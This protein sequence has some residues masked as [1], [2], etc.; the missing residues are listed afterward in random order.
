VDPA[1]AIDPADVLARQGVLDHLALERTG[2]RRGVRAGQAE[3]LDRCGHPERLVRP[4]R[5]VSGDVV[6]ERALNVGDGGEDPGREQLVA[7]GAVEPLD[8]AGGGRRA[9]R[10]EQVEDPVL[11]ADPVEQDLVSRSGGTPVEH[12]SVVREHRLGHP[13]GGERLREGLAER[14]CGGAGHRR[15]HDAEP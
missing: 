4:K 14:A 7:K 15:G 9:D 5:V 12:S 13:V 6:I 2:E 8:L 10:G 1:V 3:P 11:A